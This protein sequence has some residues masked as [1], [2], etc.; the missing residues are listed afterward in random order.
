MKYQSRIEILIIVNNLVRRGAEQ[1]L[2]NFIKALPPNIAISIFKFSNANNEF[3]ELFKYVPIKVYSNKHP[4]TY[5]F[6]KLKPLYSCLSKNKY[7]AIITLGL[8]PALFFGRFF[9][10]FSGT[11]IIYSFLN[12]LENFH[13]IPRLRTKYFDILNNCLNHFIL[14]FRRKTIFRFFSNSEKLSN[15]VRHTVGNYPV[16]TIYNGLPIADIQDVSEHIPDNKTM[17]LIN[18]I[19]GYPTIVQVGA[20]DKNKNQI[21]SLRRFQEI[22]TQV[23]NLRFLI[24]GDGEKR[25]ELIDFAIS[26]NIEKQVIFAGKMERQN[27]LCLIQRS[28]I[29]VLTSESESFPNVIAEAQALS[30]PVVTF[31]VGAVR[32]MVGQNITGYVTSVGDSREFNRKLVKLLTDKKLATKMGKLGQNRVLRLFSMDKKVKHFLSI[33]HNDM[34]IPETTC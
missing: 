21:F 26:N 20:L 23:P 18:Q 10:L 28:N 31:D 6:L 12:T 17:A 34:G 15:I 13:K 14:L 19:D 30:L 22:R 32:E 9:A 25:S 1:Q 5:N 7:D 33:L 2:F 24:I 4:G 3:P 11:K 16:H 8:G 29:L 27:C